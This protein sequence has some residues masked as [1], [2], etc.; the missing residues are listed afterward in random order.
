MKYK[1]INVMLERYRLSKMDV[2]SRNSSMAIS[3]EMKACK[4]HQTGILL[5]IAYAL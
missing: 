1:Q 5:G 3:L 2:I 4:I